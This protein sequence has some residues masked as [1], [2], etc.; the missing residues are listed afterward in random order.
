VLEP[1][2]QQESAV[3]VEVAVVEDKK[4]F[5]PIGIEPLD[6]MG[7]AAGEIPKIADADIV[8][9][10]PAVGVNRRDAGRSIEHVGPFR[11]LVPVQFAYPSRVQPHIHAGDV[12]RNT[13]LPGG[14]LA[15]PAAARLPHMSVREGKPQI[16]QRP[17]IGCGRVN[18]VRILTFAG[19]AAREGVGAPDARFPARV[20]RLLR[21]L[22][23]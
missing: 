9:K 13:E 6:R 11:L 20:G 5:T 17:G 3:L 21:G 10:I 22:G 4:E 16:G 1:V 2:S 12:L 8:D 19:R 23:D 7:N 18:H 14:P 15:G